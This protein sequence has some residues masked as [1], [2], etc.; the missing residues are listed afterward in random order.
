MEMA[1]NHSIHPAQGWPIESI[2]GSDCP[3]RGGVEVGVPSGLCRKDCCDPLAMS[4][5]NSCRNSRSLGQLLG[6]ADPK[7]TLKHPG[8]KLVK[9][10]LSYSHP[11]R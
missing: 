3:T 10:D 8:D 6:N 1:R 11:S 2:T 5:L 9:S 7:G 4:A